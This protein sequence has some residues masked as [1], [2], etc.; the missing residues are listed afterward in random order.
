MKLSPEQL[1]D[2]L[3]QRLAPAYCISGDEPLQVAE[4]TDAVREAAR[5]AGVA[6]REVY[7]VER[8]F[9][10][11]TVRASAATRSLF[12]DRRLLELRFDGASP[13]R[14]AAAGLSGVIESA[15]EGLC[16][17]I[18]AGRLE[19]AALD[20]AW[21]A[22]VQQRGAWVPVWP[23]EASRLRDW[24]H[25][26]C[27]RAGLA[28]SVDAL[29]LLFDRTEGNL[30]AARQEID[31]LRLL[32]QGNRVE[33]EDVMASVAD[34]ARFDIA[35]LGEAAM[36]GDATR[37]LRIL[38]ALRAEGVEPVLIWWALTRELHALWRLRRHGVASEG[39]GPRRGPAYLRTLDGARGRASTLPFARL[40]ERAH[41]ADRALKGRS[42]DPPWDA[43]T[44]YCAELAGLRMPS[45]MR[46]AGQRA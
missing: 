15:G 34:S 17:L 16:V 27:Q 44:A 41:Q 37:A 45:A 40:S 10:W 32:V 20:S 35:A 3:R 22:D 1:P 25:S 29:E 18:V 21:L 4:C 31:K 28:P 6:Q 46:R 5:Q 42:A 8:G 30:L 2:R 13:G 7:F 9:D 24:L 36:S 14:E 39:R 43:L 11:S 19:R 33:A 38:D 23:I 12:D 26:R